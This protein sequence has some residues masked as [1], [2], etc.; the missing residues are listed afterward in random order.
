M[1]YYMGKE[2]ERYPEQLI[3]GDGTV[4]EDI[5]KQA[6]LQPRKVDTTNSELMPGVGKRLKQIARDEGWTEYNPFRFQ[7][8]S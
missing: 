3:Q 7:G 1:F 6:T 2:R 8:C 4:T 5:S